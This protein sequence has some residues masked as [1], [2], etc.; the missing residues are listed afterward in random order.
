MLFRSSAFRLFGQKLL[1]QSALWDVT[2]PADRSQWQATTLRNDGVIRHAPDY[3]PLYYIAACSQQPE[4]IENLPTLALFG[5][6]AES[7]YSHYNDEVRRHIAAG[8][9]LQELE[10]ELARERAARQALEAR[11]G[12][13]EET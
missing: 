2:T 13:A 3:P 6:A 5:D 8:L 1:F 10:A 7:V 4:R 11:L 12:D 9:R